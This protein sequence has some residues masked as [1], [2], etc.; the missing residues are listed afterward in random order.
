MRTVARSR[1]ALLLILS[2]AFLVP[3]LFAKDAPSS[4]KID[5]LLPKDTSIVIVVDV[6]QIIESPVFK[7]NLLE[8]AKKHLQSNEEVSKTLSLLNFDPFKDLDRITIAAEGI[9]MEPKG[10]MVARGKF[11]KEKIE[12]KAEAEA[13][14]HK[15]FLKIL[16]E[17]GHKIYEVSPPGQEK[18]AFI[19]VIDGTAIVASGDKALVK[20]ALAKSASTA[21]S[22]KADLAKLMEAADGSLFIAVPG[23]AL[24]SD[25][26]S[27]DKAKATVAKID[28]I[29]L[30]LKLAK[31]LK[32]S[33]T[34][35]TKSDENAK[36]IAEEI[37]EGLNSA[38]GMVAFM[39]SQQKEAAAAVDFMN[40]V[41]VA[42]EGKNIT[43]KAELSEEAIDKAHAARKGQQ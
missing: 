4:G 33:T 41:K 27:D 19:A 14:E 13:K 15:D 10:L 29:L 7:K 24:K 31:D 36:E 26:I 30:S 17:D 21:P 43:I 42:V 8:D 6:K 37:K 16:S 5:P 25:L 39:A 32:V 22:I 34:V 11:D 18:P 35:A 38:K 9:A 28:H 2:S 40:A 12:A 3:A 23:S 20:E 1:L